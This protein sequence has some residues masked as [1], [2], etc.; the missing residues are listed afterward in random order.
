LGSITNEKARDLTIP[1]TFL[2]SKATYEAQ[3]YADADGTDETHNPESVT[4]SK[5]TVKASD[6]LKLHLGGAGGTAIR[7]KKI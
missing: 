1:L 5:K 4:I 6:V 2:D 7:F 3:I